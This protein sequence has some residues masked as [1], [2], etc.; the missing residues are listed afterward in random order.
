MVQGLF[1]KKKEN[2][3]TLIAA[4]QKEV[5]AVKKDFTDKIE[6]FPAQFK[7]NSDNDKAKKDMSDKLE[8]MGT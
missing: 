2:I 4:Y 3:N 1:D 7:M 8:S 5:D 6:N